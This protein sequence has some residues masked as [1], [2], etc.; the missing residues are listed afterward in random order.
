MNPNLARTLKFRAEQR[1]SQLYA[2]TVR[3]R[4]NRDCTVTAFMAITGVDYIT[5]FDALKGLGRRMRSGLTH[6]KIPEYVAA[7]KAR[8]GGKRLVRVEGN[9]MW[10][11]LKDPGDRSYLVIQYD[12]A[13]AIVDGRLRGFYSLGPVMQLWRVE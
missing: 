8:L 12:H 3:A 2:D 4:D 10:L 11:E 7:I 5:A 1:S 6:D 13:V 9:E